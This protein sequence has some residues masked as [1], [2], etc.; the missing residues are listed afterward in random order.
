MIPEVDVPSDAPEVEVNPRADTKPDVKNWADEDGRKMRNTIEKFQDRAKKYFNHFYSQPLRVDQEN[1]MKL[2]DRYFR[3]SKQRSTSTAQYEVHKSN[4]VTELFHRALRA[5]TS[6]SIA[7][8][9]QNEDEL[10]VEYSP[11]PNADDYA[12][13]FA[14]EQADYQNALESHIMSA[15]ERRAKIENS[16]WFLN[17][18]GNQIY[19]M[20]WDLRTKEVTRRVPKTDA[21]GSIILNEKQQIAEYEFKTER[22]TLRDTSSLGVID[23]A[24]CYFDASILSTPELNTMEQQ[25][26]IL[27]R[28]RKTIAELYLMQ[29]DG[30]ISNVDKITAEHMYRGESPSNM[31]A[32]RQTNAGEGPDVETATGEV[33]LWT[34][35]MVCPIDEKAGKWD[36]KK[37]LPTRWIGKFAGHINGKN[38]CLSLIRNPYFADEWNMKMIYSHPDDKGAFHMGYVDLSESLLEELATSINQWID[39]KTL[40]N[41]A[42]WKTEIGAIATRDRTFSANTLL[43]MNSGMFEK[44]ERVIVPSITGDMLPFIQWLEDEIMKALGADKAFRGEA[45]PSRTPATG[46]KLTHDQSQKPNLV[47]D[48]YIARQLFPWMAQK[49]MELWRQYS[50]PE[51]TL[52]FTRKGYDPMEFSPAELWQPLLVKCVAVDKYEKD[53][54]QRQ[55]EDK[56]NQVLLP[57]LAPL[58]GRKGLTVYGKQLLKKRGVDGVDEMFPYT[59]DGDAR[60]VALSENFAILQTG[61]PDNVKPEEDD[62]TH[63]A[64]H[65]PALEWAKAQSDINPEHIAVLEDHV[66]QHQQRLEVE[67]GQ[68][69]SPQQEQGGMTAPSN[70]EGQAMGDMFSAQEGAMQ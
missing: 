13:E 32:E 47:K 33:E 19:E 17:K 28:A 52:T 61:I 34:V 69:P 62:E 4:A 53:M 56:F 48:R 42:P 66:A 22:L 41:R 15:D 14:Q 30:E 10:P 67:Q 8:Y 5:I 18:N 12:Q 45:M 46:Y 16:L 51:K 70:M 64:Q 25:L 23:F 27:T 65:E 40:Q 24:D 59:K 9:F 63:L 31:R 7:I 58:M 50:D 26:C 2:A 57:Y 44:L 37:N 39:N 1:R 29:A 3:A 36:E 20:S 49:D 60:H 38:V 54:I 11:D 68:F 55:E 21:S 6:N 43:E 35:R